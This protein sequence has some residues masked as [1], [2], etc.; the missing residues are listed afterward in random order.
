MKTLSAP[1][2]KCPFRAEYVG[3][4]DYLRPGRRRGI[5]NDIEAGGDFPCH[6]TVDYDA[7]PEDFDGD[8]LT[9]T[10]SEAPCAGLDLVMLRA[11]E[12]HQELRIRIGLKVVDPDRLLADNADVKL[13]AYPDIQ[14]DGLDDV[15][16][17]NVVGPGCTAPAGF[18]VGGS[19]QHGEESAE[20]ICVACGDPVCDACSATIGDWYGHVDAIICDNCNE[21]SEEW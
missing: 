21:E 11:R 17:C 7:Q 6:N 1:C 15:E 8:G 10:G 13:W 5:V 19:V 9:R 16:P 20:H 14:T 3:D 4:S 2:A 12:A 18:L